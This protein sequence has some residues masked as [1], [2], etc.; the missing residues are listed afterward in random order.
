VGLLNDLTSPP[1]ERYAVSN[2]NVTK[3]VQPGTFSDQLT[4]ILRDGVNVE[5]HFDDNTVGKLDARVCFSRPWRWCLKCN[6]H[7]RRGLAVTPCGN[8][9]KPK[10]LQSSLPQMETL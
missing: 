6:R 5:R 10:F 8:G 3:L 9:D 7:Y 1:K 2:T 4:D